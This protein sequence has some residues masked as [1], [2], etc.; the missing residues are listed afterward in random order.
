MDSCDVGTIQCS[1]GTVVVIDMGTVKD[2]DRHPF[3]ME[4]DRSLVTA[5]ASC[6]SS[7]GEE[8]IPRDCKGFSDRIH[9]VSMDL[10]RRVEIRIS[11]PTAH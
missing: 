7:L 8:K 2:P 5:A 1:S 9:I 3:T 4:Y 10:P 11:P 6:Y